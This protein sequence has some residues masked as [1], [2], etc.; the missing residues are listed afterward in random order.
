MSWLLIFTLAA[1]LFLNR[2]LLL[3]PRLPLRIPN[4]VRQALGYSAPCLLTAIC[5]GIILNG[6]TIYELPTNPYWYAT[7]FT[8][9]CAWL[10]RNML[11]SVLTSLAGFY[12]IMYFAGSLHG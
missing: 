4:I 8:V 5:G 3:E 1:V 10:I 12:L 6:G 11:L 7:I 9:L 2:Y